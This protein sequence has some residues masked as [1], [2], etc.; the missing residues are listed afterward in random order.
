MKNLITIENDLELEQIRNLF[1][2]TLQQN[3]VPAIID[4]LKA[5]EGITSL[6][7]PKSV[8]YSVICDNRFNEEVLTETI[9]CLQP[10]MT[11][12][13]IECCSSNNVESLFV[14]IDF[15]KISGFCRDRQKIVKSLE[16]LESL[17]FEF[18]WVQNGFADR[19][20]MEVA[21]K[22]FTYSGMLYI[23]HFEEKGSYN[24]RLHINAMALPYLTFIGKGVGYTEFDYTIY[25]TL[26]SLYLK[27]LYKLLCE[28]SNLGPQYNI[29]VQEFKE[30]LCLPESNSI[31]QIENRVIVPMKDYLKNV[32]SRLQFDYEI[33]SA[34]EKNEE[35][36]FKKRAKNQIVFFIYVPGRNV[37]RLI[38]RKINALKNVL[39]FIADKERHSDVPA[40]VNAIVDAGLI[41]KILN[42]CE[43]YRHKYNK[44]LIDDNK[45]RNTLLKIV[46]LSVPN[47][48]LR[49]SD[50]IRNANMKKVRAKY[51]SAK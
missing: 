21:E 35:F 40:V 10:F 47:G 44:G 27:K 42:K 41:D 45:F 11:N 23:G 46:R 6:V 33:G 20:G 31:T 30:R 19:N 24:Y 15:S 13:P 1:E 2:G 22:E 14:S 17:R 16:S 43:Y 32:N 48:D 51:Q 5:D 28:W 34:P 29:S 49:S 7:Q 3:G 9:R 25:S 38:E 50:H 8:T 12:N 4:N 36:G 26:N 39:L 37:T 18:K